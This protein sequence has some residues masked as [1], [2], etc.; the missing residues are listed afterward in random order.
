VD[1]LWM[2]LNEPR[3]QL[4]APLT[5]P[6]PA[7]TIPTASSLPA[8]AE[9]DHS[10]AEATTES[11]DSHADHAW[12]AVAST[13][14]EKANAARDQANNAVL[15]AEAEAGKNTSNDS[16]TSQPDWLGQPPRMVGEVYRVPV[17]AGPYSSLQECYPALR[18]N[19]RK[20]VNDRIVE[21]VRDATGNPY[22]PVPSLEYLNLGNSFID[23]ELL[24]DQYVEVSETSVGPMKTAWGLLEFTPQHDQQLVDAWKRY[25]RRDGIAKTTLL[26]LLVLVVLGSVFV[27][28]Q[29]DTWTRGYYTKRLFL[30]VPAA[31]IAVIVLFA[32]ATA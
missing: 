2:R 13:A 9:Y 5:Q 23:R 21:L 28:L 19:M 27:L 29:I 18:E 10:D 25:A 6:G 14:A 11:A 7:A 4:S 20:V 17:E 32:M 15:E 3:I 26:A 12:D 8:E 22:V 31:I 1:E 16:T 30:G 24:T